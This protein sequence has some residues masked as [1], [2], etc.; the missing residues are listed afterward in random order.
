MNPMKAPPAGP[1]TPLKTEGKLVITQQVKDDS[2]NLHRPPSTVTLRDPVGLKFN[3]ID[4]G[5][6]TEELFLNHPAADWSATMYK[7]DVALME[8]SSALGILRTSNTKGYWEILEVA[9]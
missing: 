6:E 2:P 8:R 1:K 9:K 5:V 4:G 7:G 3:G